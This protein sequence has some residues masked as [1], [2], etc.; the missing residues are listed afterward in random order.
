M[1]QRFGIG[2][3]MFALVAC[4]IFLCS[5]LTGQNAPTPSL[6]EQL[7]A[8]YKLVKTGSDAYGLTVVDPGTVLDVQKGGLLGVPPQSVVFCP[9]KFQDGGLKGLNGFCAAMVKQNSRYLQVGTK[10][11]PTKIDVN[12]EKDRVSFQVMEC[13]SCNG[14]QQPSF[15]KSEV[16]FQFAKGSLRNSSVPQVEDTIS[17]VLAID[18][19]GDAQQ[20]NAQGPQNQDTSQG[21]GQ[22][23]QQGPPPEPQQIEKGQT[24]DQVKAALGTPEK[25]VNLGPKQIY[26]YK[27]LKVTFLNGKVSDV[28]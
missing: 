10:V 28:Q 17:Q 1:R 4:G 12:L 18:S 6:Q 3:Y 11:Y 21:G 22:G 23:Q 25:I 26:V 13:D 9:A 19:G 24:P 5:E 16:V 8:Q 7:K 14:V 15:Y 2:T 20:S 27:D